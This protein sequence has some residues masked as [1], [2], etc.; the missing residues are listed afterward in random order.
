VNFVNDEGDAR[1]HDAY[2]D[3]TYARLA[4]IKRRYDP[5][6]VFR[7]NQNVEPTRV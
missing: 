3:A 1:I 4:A 7:R 6:N 2:P 5:D